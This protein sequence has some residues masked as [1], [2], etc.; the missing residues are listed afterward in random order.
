LRRGAAAPGDRGRPGPASR[1]LVL[2][3]PTVGLD[4]ERL[5]AVL[6]LLE[7]ARAEGC[8][9]VAATHDERLLARAD[10]VVDLPAPPVRGAPPSRGIRP[11]VP[12]APAGACNPLTLCA[13]GLLAA[14]GSFAVTSWQIGALAL[15]PVALL[16]PLAVP[17]ARSAALRLAPILLSAATLAWTTAL[18]SPLA[19]LSGAAWLLG[20][21]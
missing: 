20:A 8:A 15:A 18:L 2:D 1:L 11:P 5:A 10:E 21:K 14:I 9:L 7:A 4:Q 6:A 3:E 12:R 17:S 16:A 19:P 13:I